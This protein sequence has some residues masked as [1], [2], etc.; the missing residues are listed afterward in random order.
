MKPAHPTIKK[1]IIAAKRLINTPAGVFLLQTGG[2]QMDDKKVLGIQLE[3]EVY[4]GFRVIKR[5]ALG[6]PQAILN[7]PLPRGIEGPVF[8]TPWW[9]TCPQ[10]KRDIQQLETECALS[11]MLL[12]DLEVDYR[13]FRKRAARQRCQLIPRE[14]Q[15]ELYNNQPRRYREMVARGVAG[16]SG[17]GWKCLHAHYAFFL[18]YSDY[19]PGQEIEKMLPGNPEERCE[20]HCEQACSGY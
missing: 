5:C 17:P 14:I 15:E 10:L 12:V 18:L 7:N 16:E 9:L 4:P 8:S 6:F 19:P 3:R 2:E 20:R 11:F 13:E 1:E